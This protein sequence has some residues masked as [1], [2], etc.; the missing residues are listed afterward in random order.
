[1]NRD[2]YAIALNSAL[3]EIKKAYPDINH[4]FLFTN[5][6]SIITGDQE[7]SLIHI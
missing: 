4:S 7:L 3:T 6:G 2:P 5:K 1:M